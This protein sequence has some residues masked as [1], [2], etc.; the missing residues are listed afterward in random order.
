[1]GVQCFRSPSRCSSCQRW[2]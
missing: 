1:M 2:L